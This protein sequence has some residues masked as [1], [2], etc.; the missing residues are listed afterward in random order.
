MIESKPEFDHRSMIITVRDV[1]LTAGDDLRSEDKTSLLASV[2][3][4]KPKP[5]SWD[6]YLSLAADEG[7][8]DAIYTTLLESE[9]DSDVVTFAIYTFTHWLEKEHERMSAEIHALRNLPTSMLAA[10]LR[11]PSNIF[12][13]SKALSVFCSIP[14]DVLTDKENIYV[15]TEQLI[16][17]AA[18][19]HQHGTHGLWNFVSIAL[20]RTLSIIAFKLEEWNSLDALLKFTK[21]I[22]KVV[23][24]NSGHWETFYLLRVL[25][26]FRIVLSQDAALTVGA[27]TKVLL[28]H[29]QNASECTD[30]KTCDPGYATVVGWGSTMDTTL[31]ILLQM[32]F[33]VNCFT[34]NHRT[35]VGVSG[36]AM[37][38]C[39]VPGRKHEA[40]ARTFLDLNSVELMCRNGTARAC[41]EIIL[42]HPEY[43]GLK[44]KAIEL[45]LVLTFN[46]SNFP[47]DDLYR[48]G[49]GAFALLEIISSPSSTGLGSNDAA[50]QDEMYISN[51][52]SLLMMMTGER[53]Y[54]MG[55]LGRGYSQ[56]WSLVQGPDTLLLG[57]T[58]FCYLSQGSPDAQEW[59]RKRGTDKDIT[60]LFRD[61]VDLPVFKM[62]L[63]VLTE[64]QSPELQRLPEI[65]GSRF[66]PL[67]SVAFYFT[68]RLS[69][70]EVTKDNSPVVCAVLKCITQLVNDA[71][72]RSEAEGNRVALDLANCGYA[73]TLVQILW[74]LDP[75]HAIWK[76]AAV[77][78]FYFFRWSAD[79]ELD[80]VHRWVL[81]VRRSAE[82]LDPKA[83]RY[84]KLLEKNPDIE[85]EN[86]DIS[87][88]SFWEALYHSGMMKRKIVPDNSHS[89]A[90]PNDL[91]VQRRSERAQ[92]RAPTAVEVALAKGEKS[93]SYCGAVPGA[94]MG[95]RLLR[96][97]RCQQAWYCNKECQ[98]SHWR[99]SHAKQCRKID[100][101]DNIDV[102]D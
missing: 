35:M 75:E 12:L 95:H 11:F 72:R 14:D 80:T 29:T 68:P 48:S 76:E 3:D 78:G 77:A 60:N 73:F 70:T 15:W 57:L 23:E 43:R 37:L 74:H 5:E 53:R 91:V 32:C 21:G 63:D 6:A 18:S 33:F 47:I 98:K 41:I 71:D 31:D 59:L 38:N 19:A 39:Y 50:T 83:K 79:T 51:A 55:I 81:H 102:V 10:A 8:A 27:C 87:R 97:A 7:L 22:L 52:A 16:D 20:S 36:R 85:P 54:K 67:V 88:N 44:V 90:P 42:S 96:C 26:S 28:A 24:R 2:A 66:A 30:R 94:H 99:I 61:A 58:A 46:R 89:E 45:L 1:L 49:A 62:A 84:R 100:T 9:D 17:V 13:L 34:E 82:D 93:C 56:L 25:T 101:V 65:L 4:P 92:V 69:D 64:M 40:E 86:F